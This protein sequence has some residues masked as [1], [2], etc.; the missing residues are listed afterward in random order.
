LGEEHRESNQSINHSVNQSINQSIN[1]SVNQSIN[2]SIMSTDNQKNR[3]TRRTVNVSR[4]GGPPL[5]MTPEAAAKYIQQATAAAGRELKINFGPKRPPSSNTLSTNNNVQTLDFADF[6]LSKAPP[7]KI[8]SGNSKIKN[9]DLHALKETAAATADSTK[10]GG[11][12]K[13][14]GP[15]CSEAEMKALMG[16]FVEI[17]GMSVDSKKVKPPSI[18]NDEKGGG[19]GPV[20]MFGN[21]NGIPMPP[22]GWS[23]SSAESMAAATAG[24]F[25][26]GAS[27]WEAIR[28][29]YG[30]INSDDDDYDD[31]K[32]LPN[33]DDMREMF[34]ASQRAAAQYNQTNNKNPPG[35]SAADWS[36]LEQVAMD[37]DFEKEE[38]ERR[39]AKKRE[40]KQRKKAKQKEEAA[41][42]AME[43]AQKKREKSVLSWRSRVVSACQS[44]ETAKLDALLQESPLRKNPNSEEEKVTR[45]FSF[46]HL[47]FLLPNSV[48]KN[49][50]QLTWGLE[51]RYKLADYV[52]SSDLPIA[53]QP[54]RNGRTALHTACF[55]GDVQFIKLLLERLTEYQDDDNLIPNLYLNMTCDDSGWSPLHYAAVS[56]SHEVL[57]IL[58]EAGCDT[59]TITDDT[60]TWRER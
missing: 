59:S 19:K 5:K 39:A 3:N 40:K 47:E 36:D 44:N 8:R 54:L 2:Q 15:P 50:A 23:E 46:P 34:Q 7:P 29:S 16:M 58:L 13:K 52:L 43:A 38:K 9:L 22:G 32:S 6:S 14:D 56:G 27:T 21:S 33:L 35:I 20:F 18:K 51:S 4:G 26:D 1:Q 37:D 31:D 48:A 11:K 60:H 42:K 49:Q 28:R 10:K 57:E 30:G 12:G 25:A 17:M 41:Q 45:S 55:H 24:F 53:F